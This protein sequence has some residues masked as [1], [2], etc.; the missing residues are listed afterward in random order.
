MDMSSLAAICRLALSRN[1]YVYL[2]H[3]G[4]GRDVYPYKI[5]DGKLYC[6][7]M[8]HP[9]RDVESLYLTNIGSARMSS[10]SINMY[11]AYDSEFAP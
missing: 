5:R 1:R 9:D 8:L 4:V 7:C 6:F 2:E 3:R 10:A 11:F